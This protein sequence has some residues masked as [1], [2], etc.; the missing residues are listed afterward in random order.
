MIDRL[1]RVVGVLILVSAFVVDIAVAPAFAE[2]PVIDVP[3]ED[4]AMNAAMAKARAGLP[5]F[6]AA[7]AH[8]APDTERYS[9]KV[10][11]KEGDKVEHF[12]TSDIERQGD[13]ITAVIANEPDRITNVQMG[14]RI[15][16]PEGDISDWM[17]MRKG[18]IVGNQTLRVLLRYMPEDEA[19]KWKAMLEEP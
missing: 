5:A 9:L 4:A 3:R 11:I 13:R 1:A 17:Y 2:D 8:P 7:L 19:A 10:A 14:Q 12:W 15:N 16:V 6:W 18:K